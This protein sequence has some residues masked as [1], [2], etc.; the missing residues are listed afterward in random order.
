MVWLDRAQ[1]W[2]ALLD[3]LQLAPTSNLGDSAQL[4]RALAQPDSPLRTL[5]REATRATAG[6]PVDAWFGALRAHVRRQRRRRAGRGDA[7]AA[8][9]SGRAAGRRR[10]RCPPRRDAAARGRWAA[11]PGAGRARGARAAEPRGWRSCT[12]LAAN[13]WQAAL[14]QPLANE[15]R[16]S[17]RA[18]LRQ[19]AG[20]AL[21]VRA[22]RRARGLARRL[23]ARLRRRRPVR[24]VH[25]APSRAAWRGRARRCLRAAAARADGARRVLPRRRPRPGRAP[26][27]PPA[28][29]RP[30]CG[31][32]RAR[33]RRS[34]AAFPAR[35][36]AGSRHRLADARRRRRACARAAGAE[37]EQCRLRLPRPMGAAAAARPRARRARR[38]RPTGCW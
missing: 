35:H 26:G 38:D 16:A 9:A 30:G 4:A 22:R 13:Q 23:R 37:R 36:E 21:P 15:A 27:V 18:G 3:E 31:R 2:Q 19:H 25:P 34:G 12:Q 5:P 28:R 14:R 1:S 33:R 6:G 8:G 32:I 24:R 7:G 10:C 17:A 11:R 29:A 20:A